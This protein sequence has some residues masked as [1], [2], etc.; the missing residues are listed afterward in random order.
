MG[1]KVGIM[2][3]ILAVALAIVT[4][5]S[6]RTHTEAIMRQSAANDAWA[7]YQATRVKFHNLELG[8]SMVEALGGTG[9]I[10][11]KALASFATQKKDYE[12]RS[13]TIQV[14][15][16]NSDHAAEASEKRALRY[17][18]GEGLLE[19]AVVLSSLYFISRKRLFP[20]IGLSAGILGGAIA[21][22]GLMM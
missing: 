2:A 22:T 14:E 8:E 18:I 21:L 3:A 15:A 20:A 12:G 1:Q 10:A 11:Q 19:I 17:D 9:E 6:H 7:H 16:E 13:R 5:A 4:I